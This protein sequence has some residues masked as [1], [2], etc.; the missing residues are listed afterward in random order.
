VNKKGSDLTAEHAET[1]EVISAGARNKD[2][3]SVLV[4]LSALRVLCGESNLFLT[5]E[6]AET[7]EVK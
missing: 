1:A 7:A 3:F 4:F 6:H 5:A 2:I